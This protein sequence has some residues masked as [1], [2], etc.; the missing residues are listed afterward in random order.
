MKIFSNIALIIGIIQMSYAIYL[1]QILSK[2]TRIIG[3]QNKWKFIQVLIMF[4]LVSY[5]AFEIYLLGFKFYPFLIWPA[6][7]YCF[8]ASFVLLM[9]LFVK[10]SFDAITSKQKIFVD[11]IF[12]SLT[13]PFFVINAHDNSVILNNAIANTR[14]S[15]D[16]GVYFT[17]INKLCAEKEGVCPVTEV[18]KIKEPVSVKYIHNTGEEKEK[19]YEISAYPILND[20]GEVGE[21]IISII[22][23]TER[24]ESERL[25]SINS[26]I[27][28]Y[29]HEINNPLTIAKGYLREGINKLKDGEVK[30]ALSNVNLALDRMIEIVKSISRLNDL[31]GGDIK[32]EKYFD[33]MEM[34]KIH[35]K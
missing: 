31:K 27:T 32:Y 9:L 11:S 25:K 10:N 30:S 2:K 17:Q 6:L 12:T 21:I 29:N 7:V 24:I 5:V 4:F 22:D 20:E 18:K 34:I 35:K 16:N 13:H 1:S 14:I 3:F 8:G 15:N 26:M 19:H 28:T 33:D 23:I